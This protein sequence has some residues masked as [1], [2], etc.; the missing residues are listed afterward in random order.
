MAEV[1]IK[2]KSTVNNGKYSSGWSLR[3][4][5]GRTETCRST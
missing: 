3:L 1:N 5:A 2:K 4:C